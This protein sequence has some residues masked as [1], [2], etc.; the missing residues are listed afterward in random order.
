M[1]KKWLHQPFF[2]KLRHWEYWPFHV[3]YAPIYLY[4]LWLM[5]K[6][7]S[8]FFF[9]AANPTIAN[10]GFLMESKNDIYKL[11]PQQFY[12]A[13]VFVETGTPLQRILLLMLQQQIAYPCIAK[14]DI[15][16]RGMKVQLVNNQEEL[17]RYIKENKVNFLIQQYIPYTN[18]AGIFYCRLPW[19]KKGFITGIVGKELLSITG[20]GK[21]EIATLLKKDKRHVLQ[22][23]TLRQTAGMQLNRIPTAGE[24]VLLVPYGNHCRGAKFIDITHLADDV[25]NESIDKVCRQ[26]PGFYFGRMD[27]R[28]NTWEE[29]SNGVNFSIIELNGAGS[30][31][32]HIYDPRHSIGFA[33]KEIVRHLDI[34][35]LI[36]QYNHKQQGIAYLPFKQGIRLLK[37]NNAYVK[38]LNG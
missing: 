6:A 37:D 19:Q 5:V 32:T 35:Y 23:E 36:S 30:E 22:L 15:G 34:L 2:I 25:L 9:N 11:I 16:M 14:P 38:L 29:L 17:L 24:E 7:K 27:I 26:I 31:P 10:G 28:Y 4:W 3:V 18:E 1:I 12:P 21:D 33:W 8:A 13:T 20:N